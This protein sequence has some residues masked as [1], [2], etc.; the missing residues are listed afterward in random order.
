M[1][2]FLGGLENALLLTDDKKE[3]DSDTSHFKLSFQA[4]A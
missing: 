4:V 3:R 2:A 1:R